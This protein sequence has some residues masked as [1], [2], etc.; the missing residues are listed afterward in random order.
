MYLFKELHSHLDHF[1]SDLF[2]KLFFFQCLHFIYTVYGI[3]MWVILEVNIKI[4][5]LLPLKSHL[6]FSLNQ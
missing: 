2:L 6:K 1:F 3:G 5:R 4:E